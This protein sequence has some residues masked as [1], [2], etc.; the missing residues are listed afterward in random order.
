MKQKK[1]II[2]LKLIK[3]DIS[4]EEFCNFE[5]QKSL[6]LEDD[7]NFDDEELKYLK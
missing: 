2:I 5:I 4:F 3:E 7:D 6:D 1:N